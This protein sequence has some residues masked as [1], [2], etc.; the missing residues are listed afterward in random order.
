MRL[1]ANRVLVLSATLALAACASIAPP[2]P[3]SL[4]LPKPPSDLKAV[5]KGE[6]VTLT[7][8]IPTV[9]TDRQTIRAVGL[10]QICRG[11]ADLKACGAPA[12]QTAT[13][14]PASGASSS[15]QKATATYIDSLPPDML[16]RSTS[17]TISYAVEVLNHEGRGAGLSNRVPV[18]LLETLPPP[19]DLE[20]KVTG[21]G[22]VLAWTNHLPRANPEPS[23]RYVYRLYRRQQGS[24]QSTLVGELPNGSEP[25]FALTDSGFE[26]QKTY[27]YYADVVSVIAEPNQPEVQ[28]EGDDSRQVQVFAD[29]VFP[30]AV[31]SAL[32]AVFSGPGQETFIDLVWAPVTDFD[33]AGYNIYR[34]KDGAPPVKLNP[35]PL[36]TP[37]YRDHEVTSGKRYVY[38]VSAIDVRGNESARSEEASEAAP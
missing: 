7:W 18:P 12:G 2:Q 11:T 15:K 27:E 34:R 5:R 3:P 32:Q 10:T 14:R 31:P 25:R 9:T 38:S 23:L 30:P 33:L 28:V 16:T 4:D 13:K 8:T 1:H 17:A 26:W 20:A 19:Q 22:V 24:Q 21:Q 36:K 35:E 37:A 6:H 29:D